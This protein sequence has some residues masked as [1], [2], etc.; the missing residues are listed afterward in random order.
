[1]AIDVF[2]EY[3]QYQNTKTIEKGSKFK[4]GEINFHIYENSSF[5]EIVKIID[6]S[7]NLHKIT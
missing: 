1:M 3:S 7:L 5:D 4:T 6:T 2:G